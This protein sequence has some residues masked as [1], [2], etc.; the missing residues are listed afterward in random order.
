VV[1]AVPNLLELVLAAAESLV[2]SA[3]GNKLERGKVLVCA[4]VCAQGF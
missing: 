4:E 2:E 3:A 1:P